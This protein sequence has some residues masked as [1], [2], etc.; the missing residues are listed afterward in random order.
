MFSAIASIFRGVK[1][2]FA[3]EESEAFE[4]KPKQPRQA[5]PQE[6]TVKPRRQN[7][8]QVDQFEVQVATIYADDHTPVAR[9][10]AQS[11]AGS[12]SITVSERELMLENEN[13]RLEARLIAVEGELR[14]MKTS[15]RRIARELFRKELFED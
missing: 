14:Q 2:A 5:A 8:G 4:F 7:F 10:L 6:A 1:D 11:G 9:P 3:L 12:T 15:M 13:H